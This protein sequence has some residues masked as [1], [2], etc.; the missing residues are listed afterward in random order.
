MPGATTRT[1][2]NQITRRIVQRFGPERVILF[3]SHARGLAGPDSDV[4][5]L[6]IMDVEGSRREKAV[7]IGVALHNFDVPIDVVVVRPEDFDWR[8]DYPGTIERPAYLEGVTLYARG[9]QTSRHR[10]GVG[11]QGGK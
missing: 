1:R 6:V 9:R 10:L 5:L 11:G 2:I 7:E 4:D 3:G 8:K